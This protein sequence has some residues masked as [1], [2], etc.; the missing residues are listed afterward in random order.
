LLK[1]KCS[2]ILAPEF[3]MAHREYS[4]A[5]FFSLVHHV[6]EAG[7][8]EQDTERRDNQRHQFSCMQLVA[9][10]R[11]GRMPSQ[12]EFQHIRCHDLSPTGFSF[13]SPEP[14]VEKDLIVA[15][16]KAPFIFISAEVVHQR[17]VDLDG[18]QMLLVGCRF[19]ARIN[20]ADFAPPRRN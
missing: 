13:Y 10:Y 18:E 19:I 5:T 6:L 14:Y 11:D 4:D 15:L 20:Q 1:R 9:P 16:G 3:D 17:P 2:Q 7:K 8:V 12:A